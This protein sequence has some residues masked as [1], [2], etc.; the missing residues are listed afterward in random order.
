MLRLLGAG[1]S[2]ICKGD[3]VGDDV[4]YI[5]S[6][7]APNGEV[8]DFVEAAEGLDPAYARQ[9]MTQLVSAIEYIHKKKIAHRDLKLENCFLNE[10]VSLKVA[11]FGMQKIFDGPQGEVL[12]TKLGTPNYMAPELL[13]GGDECYEGPPVDAFAVGVM[14]FIMCYGKF[15]FSEANDVYYRR[16]HKDPI[17]A[18]NVRKIDASP[19]FLDLVV[20][21]TAPDPSKRYTM[22]EIKQHAW[23]QGPTAS[24]QE[25]KEYF[26]SLQH[27]AKAADAHHYE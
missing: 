15:P 16:L 4:F 11:D 9:L 7:I 24:P 23:F 1:R 26:Y 27:E 3:D 14:L 25:L 20:G 17:K 5:V 19:E 22:T 12:S 21:L 6:E 18:M 13:T 10:E 8:F 2:Q